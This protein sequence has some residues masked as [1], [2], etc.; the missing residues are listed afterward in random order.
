MNRTRIMI[1]VVALAV[2]VGGV[3]YAGYTRMQRGWN[4]AD[5][6][7]ELLVEPGEVT[8]MTLRLTNK[9]TGQMTLRFNSSQQYDFAIYKQQ[10]SA[11]TRVWQWSDGMMFAQ[12]ETSLE[13]AAGGSV[14]FV[15]TWEPAGPGTYRAVAKVTERSA[16][17]ETQATFVV[18]N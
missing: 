15:E 10:G 6:N 17:P 2:L 13:I 14:V 8:V 3:G 5:L 18:G 12:V 4:P 9:G 1:T 16:S 11:W 7:L